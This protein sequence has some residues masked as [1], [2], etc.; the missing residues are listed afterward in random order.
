MWVGDII[1]HVYQLLVGTAEDASSAVPD[2]TYYLD[3]WHIRKMFSTCTR[4]V[5]ACNSHMCILNSAHTPE[6]KYRE[7]EMTVE[8]RGVMIETSS[9][10]KELIASF[11]PADPKALK[12]E[13]NT[14]F[15]VVSKKKKTIT[16]FGALPNRLGARSWVPAT[17]RARLRPPAVQLECYG[18]V[19]LLSCL[20]RR[21]RLPILLRC[22]HADV[23][24][25]K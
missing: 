25:D 15:P 12:K 24:N 14:H 17:Q 19:F 13:L 23:V 18:N 9:L 1:Q 20:L 2:T 10:P 4:H 7:G 11:H 3:L 22:R 21:K 16:A 8:Y 5:V 6:V